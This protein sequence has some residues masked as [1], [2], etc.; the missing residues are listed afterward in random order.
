MV[1][2]S[3]GDVESVGISAAPGGRLWVFWQDN[4]TDVYKATRSNPA[5][6][7]FGAIVKVKSPKGAMSLWRVAG[8]GSGGSLDLFAHVTTGGWIAT[9]HKQVRPELTLRARATRSSRAR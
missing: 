3:G 1:V 2:G 6:W 9:W 5:A 4:A 7:K 8:E